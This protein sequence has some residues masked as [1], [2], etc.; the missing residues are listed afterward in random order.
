[1]TPSSFSCKALTEISNN[2]GLKESARTLR[3]SWSEDAD[4]ELEE[5]TDVISYKSGRT[6]RH[7]LRRISSRYSLRERSRALKGIV[8]EDLKSVV[9]EKWRTGLPGLDGAIERG[10]LTAKYTASSANVGKEAPG[11]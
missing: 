3:R 11:V 7:R 1:M 9:G 10:V 4:N 5:E 6:V 8:K 2:S